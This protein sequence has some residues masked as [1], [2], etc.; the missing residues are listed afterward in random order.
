MAPSWSGNG[1]CTSGS[2]IPLFS[3]EKKRLTADSRVIITRT[4]IEDDEEK[5]LS[6]RVFARTAVG[7]PKQSGYYEYPFAEK[8]KFY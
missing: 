4:Q 1:L 8:S 2:E 3:K 6:T 7:R 5:K